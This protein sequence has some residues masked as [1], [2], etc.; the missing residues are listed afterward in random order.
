MSLFI[1]AE[2]QWKN[3][4]STKIK[5]YGAL[6]NYDYGPQETNYVSKISPF[7]SHRVLFEYQIIKDIKLK[8]KDNSCK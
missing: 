5:D 4:L 1:D 8:Y 2:K 7:I 6:R 3:F